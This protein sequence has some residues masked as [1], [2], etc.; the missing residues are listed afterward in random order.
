MPTTKPRVSITLDAAD[1]EAIDRFC[2]VFGEKR[3]SVLADL[4]ST[5]V[6]QMN[7]AAHLMEIAQASPERMKTRFRE[8]LA[9]ATTEV[10]GD[11]D[12]ANRQVDA[13]LEEM[14]GELN[15][16]RR[17]APSAR[18]GAAAPRS[19]RPRPDPHPLTGGS[20]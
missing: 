16:T 14:Q 12:K 9:R 11:V 2:S 3:A 10:L 13:F 17:G 18:E 15:L 20:K 7:R 4:V 19:R 5:A 6:P 1:L 8:D